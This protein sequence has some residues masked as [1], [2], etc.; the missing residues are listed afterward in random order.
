MKKGILSGLKVLDLS[1]M[2]SGPYCT[3]M[4]ADHGAEVIKIESPTGDTSRKT[5]PFKPEDL[6]KKWSGYFVSL[7]RNK[8]SV[9]IDLKSKDG[10]KKFLSLVEKADVLVENFRPGVMDKLGL[11]FNSL[12]KI[13]NRLIYAAISGFGNP[14]FGKSPY[15]YWPS[16]DVVAQAMGGIIGITGPD[17]N[18]PT[19]VGPGVGDIFSGLMMSFGIISA[20]RMA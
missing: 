7:N 17:K 19:K 4:L 13:N 3:M 16:Y 9:V 6:E 14:Q 18:T 2:L 1:R 11:G 10:K 15:L 8:K 20:L 5:G 12:K